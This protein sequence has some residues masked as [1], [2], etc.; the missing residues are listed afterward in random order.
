MTACPCPFPDRC[1]VICAATGDPAPP[2]DQRG[3]D[4]QALA[5]ADTPPPAVTE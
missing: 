2:F 5:G 1:D 4:P 3:T